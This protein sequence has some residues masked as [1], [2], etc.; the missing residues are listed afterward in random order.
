MTSRGPLSP[1]VTAHFAGFK[2]NQRLPAD[3]R[4]NVLAWLCSSPWKRSTGE[5]QRCGAHSPGNRRREATYQAK[6]AIPLT[7]STPGHIATLTQCACL[8]SRTDFRL[9]ACSVRNRVSIHFGL[10]TIVRRIVQC[11]FSPYCPTMSSTKWA[12]K[13]GAPAPS[14]S[15]APVATTTTTGSL[16][17]ND[18]PSLSEVNEVSVS[19]GSVDDEDAS[20]KE[21]CDTATAPNSANNAQLPSDGNL[22]NK[23]KGTCSSSKY[24]QPAS[25]S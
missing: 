16:S 6:I 24:K 8:P 15:P 25:N 22:K 1:L 11:S 20:S 2:N 14:L 12:S 3:A 13:N 5:G 19:N 21:N 9:L 18:W 10:V 4:C 17:S 23:K 7:R